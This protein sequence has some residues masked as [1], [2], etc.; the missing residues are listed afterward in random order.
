MPARSW[1]PRSPLQRPMQNSPSH[2]FAGEMPKAEGGPLFGSPIWSLSSTPPLSLRDISPRKGG[3]GFGSYSRVSVKRGRGFNQP[4]ELLRHPRLGL[5][6]RPYRRQ[7]TPRFLPADIL[8]IGC[9][10]PH[11]HRSPAISNLFERGDGALMV[12]GPDKLINRRVTLP[13]RQRGK[14][15]MQEIGLESVTEQTGIRLQLTRHGVV[16]SEES[17]QLEPAPQLETGR[18]NHH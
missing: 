2:P 4:M 14:A 9:L 11:E 1:H 15:Q 6:R 5:P 8:R 12:P 10:P 16:D 3:R 17:R 18:D 7:S 13:D